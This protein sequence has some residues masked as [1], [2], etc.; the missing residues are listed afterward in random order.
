MVPLVT[1]QLVGCLVTASALS[2]D[3]ECE[4]GSALSVLQTASDARR[5]LDASRLHGA[6]RSECPKKAVDLDTFTGE[7]GFETFVAVPHAYWLH[8]T[9][10]KLRS[11]RSCGDTSA[12]YWFSPKH[13]NDLECENR[14]DTGSYHGIVY[15]DVMGGEFGAQWS[16]PPHKE[17]YIHSAITW[18]RSKSSPSI[19]ILNLFKKSFHA[20]EYWNSID[21]P[22][23]GELLETIHD[24]CPKAEVLYHRDFATKVGQPDPD[25]ASPKRVARRLEVKP[26]PGKASDWEWLEKYDFVHR[27]FDVFQSN[28]L[29]AKDYN[30]F[31]MGAMSHHRCFITT[32]GGLQAS[33]AW[34][35][36]EQVVLD[37]PLDTW[38]NGT[39]ME[40]KNHFYNTQSKFANGT[41]HAVREKSELVRAVK[42]HLLQ[43][44]CSKCTVD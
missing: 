39:S 10:K 18:P 28:G 43:N 24:T 17:H 1:L 36:G 11:T 19:M 25:V 7:F 32:R 41:V 35:G 22:L 16:P 27:T 4:A 8:D 38:I 21:Y 6:G 13:V 23:L 14:V 20:N 40:I 9:C 42:Q 31:L 29:E 26:F 34:F 15:E 12:W 3:D 37:M 5:A 44:G 33:S 30:A 2:L